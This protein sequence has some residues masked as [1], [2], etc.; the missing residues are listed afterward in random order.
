MDIYFDESRNTGEISLNGNVLNYTEQRY[1]VLVGY[2][3]DETTNKKYLRFKKK[4][5][6]H[7]NSNNPSIY[8]IKGND[9]MRK[10]N[11]DIR[12]DFIEKFCYGDNL[13]ITVYDKKFFVVTQMINWLVYRFI[14]YGGEARDLYYNLCEF[15]I[16]VD[17]AYLGKYISVTKSNT[18]DSIEEFVRYIIDYEYKECINSPYEKELA[19]LW[20]GLI[21]HIMLSDE[22][23]YEELRKD[24]VPNDRVKGKYRN[25]VVNLTCLGETILL[26]KK[27]NPSLKNDQLKIHHDEIETV[28]EYIQANWE[29][30]NLEFDN[31]THSLQV[32]ISDNISSI[33]GNLIKQLL[34]IFNDNDLLKILNN[35]YEWVKDTFRSVFNRINQKN[36]KFVISMR[37]MAV[38]KSVLSNKEFSR[39][40]S[41]KEDIINRLES[42]LETEKS[43]HIDQSDAIAML[44]R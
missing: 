16:K 2:I 19:N 43:N 8:E 13:Y 4:W 7:I 21:K 22:D 23:Y 30:E 15:L 3:E 32:Q 41:F 1:F 40:S 26:V 29:Y 18:R 25:N 31:S 11:T 9:L 10:D 37:E 38:I 27:N 28:Q 20:R 5:L 42:R 39:L 6:S 17:E 34:P 35:D 44:E 36:T 14:D 24:N 12:N 33:V